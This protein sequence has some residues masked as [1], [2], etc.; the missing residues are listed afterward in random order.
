MF[1]ARSFRSPSQDDAP[2]AQAPG[3]GGCPG[4]GRS[5]IGECRLDLS[6]LDPALPHP[7]ERG[8][9]AP[10]HPAKKGVGPDI[11]RDE[12]PLPPDPDRVNGSD[13]LR[14]GR[15]EGGE[16]VPADEGLP[17]SRHRVLV[18]VGPHP[19][20]RTL[21]ERAPRPVPDGVAVF[22][23]PRRVARV[24][25]PRRPSNVANRDIRRQQ[26]VE[27][28]GQPVRRELPRIREGDHLP[29][30]VDPGIR[31]T[32]AVD[33]EPDST[34]EV[35]QRRLERS[36]DG[37]GPRLELEPGEIRA[38]VFNRRAVSEDPIRGR[39]AV[40]GAFATCRC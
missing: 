2:E 11:D 28:L 34:R 13:R 26:A 5:T 1:S 15:T 8:G 21:P 33:G 17:G 40:S 25:V 10:D 30:C 27:G 18:Q 20:R 37:P 29:G 36:L 24:E 39:R 16:V 12:A 23:I 22:P 7:D 4:E 32:G 35:G 38:V 6:F 14:I 9:H 3:R 19:E 31:S